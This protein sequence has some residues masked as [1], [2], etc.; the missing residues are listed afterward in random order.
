M[1]G[2]SLA[3]EDESGISEKPVVRRTWA[4]RGET[5]TIV[6]SGSWKSLTMAGLLLFTPAGNRPT[7]YFRLQPG[8]MDKDDFIDFLKDIKKELRGRKL[9]LIGDGLPA[10]RAKAVTEYL[11]T[12]TSWLRVERYPSSAPELSP[13]EF[14]WSSMKTRDL[15]HVPPK[16]LPHLKRLVRRS[17]RRIK[18]DTA[19]LR[20]CLRKAGVLN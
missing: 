4:V 12:Q 3:Y 1:H 14:L 9:L 5:P 8:S 15:A 16:G 2:F 18:K 7:I 19:F 20:G 11:K 6:S 13:V 10:H 17:F